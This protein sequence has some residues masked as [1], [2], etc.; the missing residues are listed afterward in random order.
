MNNQADDQ[1][2]R[3]S[4]ETPPVSEVIIPVKK[5]RVA[6]ASTDVP[7]R[8]ANVVPAKLPPRLSPGMIMID[9]YK[10]LQEAKAAAEAQ[11]SS[12]SNRISAPFP[13]SSGTEKKRIAHVPNVM[14]LLT[15][16][17]KTTPISNP[18]LTS[19][20]STSNQQPQQQRTFGNNFKRPLP[21]T[22]AAPAPTKLPRPTIAIELGCRVPANIRQKY[23]NILV[24][25]TLKIYDR[26]EDAYERA[27]EEEKQSYAKCNSKVVYVNVITNLVQR[28]R[29]EAESGNNATPAPTGNIS[30]DISLIGIRLQKFLFFEQV[31][32][33]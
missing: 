8:P 3:K 30:N 1:K 17:P 19:N 23:L 14:G 20:S 15:A 32:G 26:E 24:D 21:N 5:Q 4:E 16:K 29:R 11:S 33:S 12:M 9:R 27:V 28:I 25:E 2:K 6:H 31:I 13:T 18:S 7:S 10:K 22:K